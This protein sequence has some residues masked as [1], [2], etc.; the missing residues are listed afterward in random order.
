MVDVFR[1]GHRSGVI[2]IGTKVDA[3]LFGSSHVSHT[4]KN[5]ARFSKVPFRDSQVSTVGYFP[6]ILAPTLE[7]GS[8]RSL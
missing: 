2:E 6:V 5:Y 1:S 7:F 8:H 3:A 4:E